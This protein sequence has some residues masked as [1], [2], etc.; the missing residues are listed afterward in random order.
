MIGICTF[1]MSCNYP[2][3]LLVVLESF[4]ALHSPLLWYFT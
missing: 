4:A 3:A 1:R 2:S